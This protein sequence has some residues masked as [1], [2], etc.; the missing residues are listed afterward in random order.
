[1]QIQFC[2]EFTAL[3]GKPLMEEGVDPNGRPYRK[4]QFGVQAGYSCAFV[5]AYASAAGTDKRSASARSYVCDLDG[6][7]TFD[8]QYDQIGYLA[9]ALPGTGRIVVTGKL[10]KS[11][12]GGRWYDNYQIRNVYAATEADK[13]RLLLAGGIIFNRD[14]IDDSHYE[15]DGILMVNGYIEQYMDKEHPRALVSQTFVLN[16]SRLDRSNPEHLSAIQFREHYLEPIPAGW[17]KS[18]WE[19]SL[20]RRR[21]ELP[22][23]VSQLTPVQRMAFESGEYTLDDLKPTKKGSIWAT[24]MLLFRPIVKDEYVSGPVF[25]GDDAAVEP[26]IYHPIL[27]PNLPVKA[28]GQDVDVFDTENLF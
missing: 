19:I 27:T 24:Q 17:T 28:G 14:S 8:N 23:D 10:K 2:G 3:K 1:M 20:R 22:F 25:Y 21:E 7:R 26:M 16:T 6:R 4:I 12:H 18:S 15:Q 9:E 13:T 5:E 11:Y